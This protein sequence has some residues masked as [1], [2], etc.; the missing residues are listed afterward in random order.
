M[1]LLFF[2]DISLE[3]MLRISELETSSR[4]SLEDEPVEPFRKSFLDSNSETG[5]GIRK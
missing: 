3:D 5:T 1:F 4:H 2:K